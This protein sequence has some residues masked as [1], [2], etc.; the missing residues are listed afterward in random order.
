MLPFLSCLP[1]ICLSITISTHNSLYDM[2]EDEGWR[3][4]VEEEGKDVGWTDVSCS[5]TIIPG[6]HINLSPLCQTAD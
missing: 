3:K 1:V 4:V 5:A 2:V 6:F